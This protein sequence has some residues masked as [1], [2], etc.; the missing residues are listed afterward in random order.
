MRSYR[1][2]FWHEGQLV[3]NM[4]LVGTAKDVRERIAALD[5]GVLHAKVRIG[6]ELAQFRR[7]PS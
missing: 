5:S 6:A 4:S 3:A 2:E 7:F 1:I